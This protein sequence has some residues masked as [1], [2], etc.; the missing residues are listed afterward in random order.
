[1][2][3]RGGGAEAEDE[4]EDNAPDNQ[5]DVS[6]RAC[7]QKV[8]RKRGDVEAKLNTVNMMAWVH[9]DCDIMRKRLRP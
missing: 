5:V 4:I 2:W 8:W 7:R 3:L 9:M 6:G 1:M